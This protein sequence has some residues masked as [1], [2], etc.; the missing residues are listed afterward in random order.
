L[1]DSLLVYSS[2]ETGIDEL[3]SLLESVHVSLPL[4][5]PEVHTLLDALPEWFRRLGTADGIREVEQR[6]GA[7]VPKPL[8]QFYRYPAVGCW[9]LAHHHTDILLESY[10]S[11][12]RPHIVTWYHRPHLVLAEFSD[13]QTI[14]AV[15][16]GTDSPRIEWGNDGERNPFDYPPCFFAKWLA[17]IARQVDDGGRMRR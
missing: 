11:S 17:N 14:C 15:Q 13:S 2:E 7:S 12:E 8:E 1:I 16:L 6:F 4:R 3:H 9:L 5:D 10:P